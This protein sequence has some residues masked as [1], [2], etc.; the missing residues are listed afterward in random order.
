MVLTHFTVLLI[1]FANVPQAHSY[2]PI[3]LCN[4]CL[5]FT[6]NVFSQAHITYDQ[7]YSACLSV[8]VEEDFQRWKENVSTVHFYKVD[9]MR[10]NGLD[11]DIFWCLKSKLPVTSD[12]PVEEIEKGELTEVDWMGRRVTG[13]IRT[14]LRFVNGE[15][16]DDGWAILKNVEIK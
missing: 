3:L 2:L 7:N 9:K 4:Y 16:I 8:S 1:T 10:W 11:V 12:W 14:R 6:A 15:L 13:E 5:S